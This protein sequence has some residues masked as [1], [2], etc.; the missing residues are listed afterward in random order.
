MPATE[1]NATIYAASARTLR[2]ALE[3]PITD[4]E[5]AAGTLIKEGLDSTVVDGDDVLDVYLSA[6]DTLTLAGSDGGRRPV[7]HELWDGD[8]I[9]AVGTLTVIPTFH[10]V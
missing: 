6:A 2:F 10:R 7:P 3:A 5:W 1:Q 9:L 8:L 4:A